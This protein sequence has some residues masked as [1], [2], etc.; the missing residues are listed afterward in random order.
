MSKGGKLSSKKFKKRIFSISGFI[1]LLILAMIFL[2]PVYA[3][4]I[5]SLKPS[6][7]LLRNGLN[8]AIEPAK[9]FLDNYIGT[10]T[11]DKHRFVTWFGNSVLLTLVQTVLTLFLSSV[12]GYGFGMYNFR[13]KNL[14]FGCVLLVMMIPMEILML[15]LYKLVIGIKL[16]NTMGG[17][18]LPF[19]TQA[20]PIFFFRQYV[21]SLP[22]DFADAGRIDGC[23][24][25]GIFIRIMAPLMKPSFASMGIF[26]AMNSWNAFLWP[27]IVLRDAKK[28]TLSIGFLT[29]LTPYGSNYQIL[30]AGSVMSIIPIV[31]LYLFFQKYFI[32]GMTAG[33]VKG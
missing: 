13:F 28:F 11:E 26:I 33:G 6:E 22:K 14:L 5:A 4:F 20:L 24:E 7:E 15:P 16:V 3:I 29:L 10:L 9:M 30:L 21:S 23:S 18:V 32:A 25:Y 12:V 17:V 2:F 19:V 1:L 8:V 27:L 31:V